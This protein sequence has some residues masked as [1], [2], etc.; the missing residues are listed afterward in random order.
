MNKYAELKECLNEGDMSNG[1]DR[2]GTVMAW[3]FAIADYAT[4]HT[5]EGVPGEWEYRPAMGGADTESVEYQ[6]ILR[7]NPS[8]DELTKF[9]AVLNRYEKKMTLAG[10]DY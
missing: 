1:G 3:L 10:M 2:W 8:A 4:F 6:N 5:G 7:I 9:G